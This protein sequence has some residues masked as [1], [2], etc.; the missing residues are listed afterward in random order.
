MASTFF[1]FGGFSALPG[2]IASTRPES[3]I[4]EVDSRTA[5]TSSGT[6]SDVAA[7][8]RVPE[9]EEQLTLP[10]G[11]AVEGTGGSRSRRMDKG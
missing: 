6:G 11:G 2:E 5:R 1:T 3:S 9:P 8:H 7:P 10:G 4:Q